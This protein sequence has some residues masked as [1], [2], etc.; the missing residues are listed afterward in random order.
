MKNRK[1][2]RRDLLKMAA[3]ASVGGAVACAQEATR[4][5]VAQTSTPWPHSNYLPMIT[6]SSPEPT[7][8][9][10]PTV[11]PTVGP[12]PTVVPTVPPPNG[13]SGRVA[14]VRANGVTNWAGTDTGNYWEMVDQ[15]V[16][17]NMVDTGL[18]NLT[19]KS[20]LTDAWQTLIPNYKTGE[21]IAIKVNFNNSDVDGDDNGCEGGPHIDAVIEPVNALVRSLTVNFG[22]RA[23]DILVFDSRRKIPLRFYDGSL[24][25]VGFGEDP[26]SC[27]NQYLTT[28]NSSR[29]EFHHPDASYDGLDEVYLTD[30][31]L[32]THY[33]INMPIMKRHHMS[34][35][36]LG[37]KNHFGSILEPYM[38]HDTM[39]LDR[40]FRQ[41]YN[42]MVDMYKNPHIRY[43]TV[44]TVGD[45]LFG[46]LEGEDSRP[47]VWSTFEYQPPKSLFF[48]TD[49][50][51]I[52]SVMAD[53]LLAEPEG[54]SSPINSIRYLQLAE[55]AGLGVHE[56]IDDPHRDDPYD[57]TGI[58]YSRTNL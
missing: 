21:K 32:N 45:G 27:E 56:H 11:A 54:S 13:L 8:T 53:F 6:R 16:V 10:V 55:N 58:T 5:A 24:Y 40:D 26:N 34:G 36:T 48:S 43:K 1:I 44:L 39:F 47:Q 14:H 30:F 46:C 4:I 22:V 25:H 2:S 3:L 23:S 12:V 50:V 28:G 7:P 37:F 57:N 17:D 18:K 31:I 29:I 52:D 49:P 42:P 9:T 51:A 15:V 20:N 19:S 41:D 38:L 33:L 35:I